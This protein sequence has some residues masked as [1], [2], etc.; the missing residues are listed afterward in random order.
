[1][2]LSAPSRLPPQPCT[3]LRSQVVADDCTPVYLQQPSCTQV[4]EGMHRLGY[5]PV[6]GTPCTP[7]QPRL[8]PASRPSRPLAP[9][10]LLPAPRG[11]H[12]TF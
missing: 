2:S 12:V 7:P 10:N 1:M 6:S 9:C 4:I 11:H 5:R 8:S 3:S